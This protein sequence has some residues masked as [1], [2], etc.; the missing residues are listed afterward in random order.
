MDDV[1]GRAAAIL[2]DHKLRMLEQAGLKV[3]ERRRLE[4]LERLAE[5][6]ERARLSGQLVCPPP[7]EYAISELEAMEK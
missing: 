7:L 3:V 6:V 2:T 5:E 4:A 1:R